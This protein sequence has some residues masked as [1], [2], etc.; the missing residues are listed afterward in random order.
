AST[1]SY[2]VPLHDALPISTARRGVDSPAVCL[3]AQRC[4][5]P[6]VH[7][8]GE[9]VQRRVL[10]ARGA[11][12]A[13][14]HRAEDARGTGLR[15]EAVHRLPGQ[16]VR[17]RGRGVA[18]RARSR[19]RGIP[20][21]EALPG[22]LHGGVAREPGVP[23]APVPASAVRGPRPEGT[24][25]GKPGAARRARHH[26]GCRQAMMQVNPRDT[27]S[28]ADPATT[29]TAAGRESPGDALTILSLVNLVLREWRLV[30]WPGI[31]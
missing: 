10:E 4:G 6:E 27:G 8:A 7:G 19:R 25:P 17:L 29:G 1:R 2:P 14:F 31:V 22:L 28:G 3:G 20:L 15:G 18:G 12:A 13:V 11:A 9:P 23:D 30:V 21:R 5:V 16:P 26:N 24:G